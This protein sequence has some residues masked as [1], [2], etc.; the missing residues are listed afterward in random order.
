MKKFIDYYDDSSSEEENDTYEGLI[1]ESNII[2]KA[3]NDF[4][5]RAKVDKVQ[6]VNI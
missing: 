3:S 5:A 2:K 4:N 6:D 1:L